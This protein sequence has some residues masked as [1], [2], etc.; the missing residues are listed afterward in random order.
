MDP[1]SLRASIPVVDRCTYLNTGSTGPSPR[2]VV[3]AATGFVQR[4]RFE[5]PCA[6]NP[7]TVAW[8]AK[9][10]ARAAV[11]DLLGADAVEIALTRSTVEGVNMVANA[12]DWQPGDV[13]VRTDLEHSA[14]RLP[15]QRLREREGVEIRVLETEGGRL[16]PASV[17]DAVAGARLLCLSSL[18]W[19]YGTRLPI[20]DVV[21]RAHE[22]GTRV[23]VDA[24]QSV[25]QHPVDVTDWGADFVAAS[26]HKWLLGPWGAGMLYV[27]RDA[28]DH[29]DPARVGYASVVETGADPFEYEPGAKRFELGSTAIAPYVGLE[30]AIEL[31][32][33]IGVRTIEDRIQGLAGRLADGLGDRVL[34]P[35]RPDAGLVSFTAADPDATV[36]RLA[37][38]GIRIRS[39]PDPSACRASV[40]A[41]NTTEDVDALLAALSAG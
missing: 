31:I 1:A 33:D 14:G 32:Q 34:G 18:S 27:D 30:R 36:E 37:S 6:D 11:A 16:D 41:F 21:E 13:V 38:E 20:A 23:L 4:H 5:T 29:L 28:L 40:H 15:W 19:N 10:A 25:G 22:A 26:G 17:A 9:D 3:D 39:I 2:P 7:Y 12:I 8:D 35:A 24:V